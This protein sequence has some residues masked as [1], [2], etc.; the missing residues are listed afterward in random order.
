MDGVKFELAL[1]RLTR[2]RDACQELGMRALH[3][4]A[5]DK[6]HAAARMYLDLTAAGIEEARRYSEWMEER[7]QRFRI[8]GDA[9]ERE[10]D[11]LLQR[12]QADPKIADTPEFKIDQNFLWLR[13]MTLQMQGDHLALDGQMH[14][15]TAD[16]VG[17]LLAA[18]FD[19][20]LDPEPNESTIAGMKSAFGFGAGIALGAVVD[21]PARVLAFYRRHAVRAAQTD[22]HLRYLSAYQTALDRWIAQAQTM[23]H[24]L[25]EAIYE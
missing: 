10:V 2:E 24:R 14:Q 5:I 13:S 7:T 17:R 1:K 3:Q 23:T 25:R 4:A 9:L 22:L 20:V 6:T 15:H 11:L 21:M 18:L 16:E 19:K 8:D 12:Q